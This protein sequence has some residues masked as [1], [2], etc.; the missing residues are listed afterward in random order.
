MGIIL[1][2]SIPKYNDIILQSNISEAKSS[3]VMI[4]N[5]ITQKT[6]QNILLSSDT[7][8]SNLDDAEINKEKENLF[9]NV[10]SFTINSTNKTHKESGKWIKT[11]ENSYTFIISD[12]L[13]VLYTFEDNS[14]ICK[15]SEELCSKV[16]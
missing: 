15:S 11:A 16:E 1:S 2:Y 8:I 14:F 4:Q 6:S 7:S 10:I 12:D 9:T 3:I 5:A 13:E